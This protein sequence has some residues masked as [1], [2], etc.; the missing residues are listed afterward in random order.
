M[1]IIKKPISFNEQTYSLEHID[2]LNKILFVDIETTGF[3][4]NSSYLYLIGCL[5]YEEGNWQLIQ[6]LAEDYIEEPLILQEFLTLCKSYHTLIHYNGNNFD[7]PYLKQKC[8][9]FEIPHPFGGDGSSHEMTG[10]DIYKRIAGF[11]SILHLENC[12]QKTLEQFL[13][14]SRED[15][16]NGGE[17]IAIYKEFVETKNPELRELL[18]L[19]NSDDMQGMFRLLP[20]LSYMDILLVPFKVVKVQA[21]HYEDLSNNLCHEIIMKIKFHTP[22]PKPI[23]LHG[24]GCHFSGEGNE[25]FLKVPCHIGELK[26][27]YSD[28][29][30][31]YYLPLE[32]MALHKSVATYVDKDYRKQATAATCYTKKEGTYLPEWD[33]VFTPI[34]KKD[35]KDFNLF[36]E[37]TDEMKKSPQTF[38]QYALHVLDMLIH[39]NKR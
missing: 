32:D 6:Y 28:Y 37:L 10:I 36:F 23:V 30:E 27:F 13:D 38:T 25:G 7:L 8:Q 15:K 4:A 16:Y 11:K 20:L 2:E 35:Y 9:E 29:K 39:E 22:F 19:H 12:K 17:L 31:Y 21:N 24:N 14:I 34:F 1:K 26:Y 5:C 3:S 18:L 33:T